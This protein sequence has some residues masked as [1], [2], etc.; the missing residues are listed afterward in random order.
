VVDRVRKESKL[1]RKLTKGKLRYAVKSIEPVKKLLL[2]KVEKEVATLRA[3]HA[4]MNK[5]EEADVFCDV[6][7]GEIRAERQSLEKVTVALPY[8]VLFRAKEKKGK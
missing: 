8:S 4:R 5:L 2:D 6:Q 7:F 3:S 1:G